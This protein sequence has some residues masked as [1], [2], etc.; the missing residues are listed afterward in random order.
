MGWEVSCCFIG[1][2]FFCKRIIKIQVVPLYSST[3]TASA[4]K[5]SYFILSKRS[6]FHLADNQIDSGP[7]FANVYV[8]T[9]F[10]WRDFVTEVYELVYWFQRI[11][12]W[13]GNGT[14]YFKHIRPMP[15][16]ACSWLCSIDL[17][18]AGIRFWKTYYIICIVCIRNS[19]VGYRMLFV[20]FKWGRFFFFHLIYWYSLLVISAD[21]H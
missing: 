3:D 14:I 16:A 4:W 7:C 15:V 18:W 2:C 8:D 10:S 13:W 11:V 21:Y 20:F 5:N 6:N 9:S 19:F 12:I 17:A 1:C